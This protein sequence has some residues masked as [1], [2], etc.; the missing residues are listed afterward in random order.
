MD[1]VPLLTALIARVTTA[2]LGY[3]DASEAEVRDDLTGTRFDINRDTIVAVQPDGDV[4]VYAQGFD[5]HDDRGWVD[6]YV[7]PRWDAA[8]FDLVADATLSA[9]LGQI[10]ASAAARGAAAARVS[11]GIYEQEAGM[12]AAYERAGLKVET[13]YWR[14]GLEL[15]PDADYAYAATPGVQL[16]HVDPADDRV[17]RTALD[18]CNETFHDH[19]GHV[20]MSYEYFSQYWRDSEKYDPESW[21]FAVSDGE[22][23]GLLLGDDTRVGEGL[24]FVRTLGVRQSLRGRGIAKALLL[25]AFD[26]YRRRGRRGVQL[27]VDSANATGATRLYESVGMRPVLTTIAMG[28]ELPV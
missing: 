8:T 3:P 25:N 17:M 16:R 13:R 18:L 21:W 5:E 12:Q 2:L 22:P 15:T 9:C 11:A 7:D 26:D 28:C 19:H 4:V 20:P 24:G 1:D 23:V 6:V 14:M 27:G 10:R